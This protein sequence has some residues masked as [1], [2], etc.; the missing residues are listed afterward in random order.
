MHLL[1]DVHKKRAAKIVPSYNRIWA[2][3][4]DISATK[5]GDSGTFAWPWPGGWHIYWPRR[6]CCRGGGNV[7]NP[8]QLNGA[9]FFVVALLAS[10][11]RFI[12][13]LQRKMKSM[14]C[15]LRCHCVGRHV[16]HVGHNGWG[17]RHKVIR[18]SHTIVLRFYIQ[19]GLSPSFSVGLEWNQ[20]EIMGQQIFFAT[21]R[22]VLP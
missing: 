16:G 8:V 22:L 5:L 21:P 1:S 14:Q 10:L 3:T 9:L 2:D 20:C 11:S 6:R 12:S 18:L 15:L 7:L 13:A 19:I 4:N 17:H